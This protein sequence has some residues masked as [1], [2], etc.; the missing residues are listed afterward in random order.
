MLRPVEFND[1]A[2]FCLL[3]QVVMKISDLAQF[4]MYREDETYEGLK[5]SME[6]YERNRRAFATAGKHT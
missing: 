5:R 2:K 1:S 3:R 6:S 4:E